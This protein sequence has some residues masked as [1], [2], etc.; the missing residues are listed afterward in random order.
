MADRES[1][2]ASVLEHSDTQCT[3]ANATGSADCILLGSH[4]SEAVERIFSENA[5][6][7]SAGL[8]FIIH[9]IHASPHNALQW[10]RLREDARVNLSIDLWHIGLLFYRPDFKEK[11]HFVLKYPA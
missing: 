4:N 2:I 5:G 9:D 7:M 8:I 11:Q 6:R 10:L 1:F 3:E